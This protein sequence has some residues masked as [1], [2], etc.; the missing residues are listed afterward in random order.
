MEPH[1]NCSEPNQEIQIDFDGP[2][3]NEKDQEIHFL[4]CIDCFYRYLH[5]DFLNKTNGPNVVNFW[6]NTSNFKEYQVISD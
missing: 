1:K 5:K 3:K 2:N 4:A 6:K